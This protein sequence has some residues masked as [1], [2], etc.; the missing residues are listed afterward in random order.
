MMSGFWIP[1][2]GKQPVGYVVKAEG[3]QSGKNQ[4]PGD[5]EVEHSVLSLGKNI[6]E[7]EDGGNKSNQGAE[8]GI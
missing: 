6:G 8:V 3:S 4:R 7:E 1:E 5:Q 2:V